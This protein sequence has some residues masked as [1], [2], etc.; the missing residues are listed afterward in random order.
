[1][2]IVAII[3]GMWSHFAPPPQPHHSRHTHSDICQCAQHANNIFRPKS[4]QWKILS[5]WQ[6]IEFSMKKLN[7]RKDWISTQWIS[8]HHIHHKQNEASKRILCSLRI[9]KWK[10]SHTQLQTAIFHKLSLSISFSLCELNDEI[11]K[12]NKYFIYWW[13]NTK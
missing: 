1:M 12:L 8:T 7:S 5:P 9:R 3:F 4:D 11:N 6:K 2:I 10:F 13:S